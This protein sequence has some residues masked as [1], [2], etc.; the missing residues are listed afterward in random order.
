M[1]LW[2]NNAFGRIKEEAIL[3]EIKSMDIS[4]VVEGY[5]TFLFLYKVCYAMMYKVNAIYYK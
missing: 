3:D 2:K 1:S 5:A 4:Y